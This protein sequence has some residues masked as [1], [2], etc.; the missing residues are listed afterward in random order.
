MKSR[1]GFF[2]AG[3]IL[4]TLVTRF[5]LLHRFDNFYRDYDFLNDNKLVFEEFLATNPLADGQGIDYD[6]L[7]PALKKTCIRSVYRNGAFVYF[8][9]PHFKVLVDSGG[10]EFIRQIETGVGIEKILSTAKVQTV[11]IHYIH[12]HQGWLYWL[13]H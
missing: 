4:S 13:H 1:I 9:I 11:N 5:V 7:P 10:S 2:I 3:C 8:P 12:N 6:D